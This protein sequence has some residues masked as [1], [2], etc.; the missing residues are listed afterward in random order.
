MEIKNREE[1]Q[2]D[3]LIDTLANAKVMMEAVAKKM[4]GSLKKTIELE[5]DFVRIMEVQ[6][7][8]DKRLSA[9][10]EAFHRGGIPGFRT[11]WLKRVFKIKDHLSHLELKDNADRT[12]QNAS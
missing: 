6:T 5:N 2:A 9:I 8:F 12:S 1:R 11:H 7:Q 10:E 4:Q 3:S